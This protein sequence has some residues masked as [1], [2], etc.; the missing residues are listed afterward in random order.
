MK[1]YPSL[2]TKRISKQF[3]DEVAQAV[4]EG[5]LSIPAI[6]SRYGISVTQ[7]MRWKLRWENE[8]EQDA[9]K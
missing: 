9:L 7:V 4:V 3:K 5:T 8:Q 1:Q 6:A 2:E